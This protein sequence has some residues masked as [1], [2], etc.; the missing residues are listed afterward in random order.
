[1]VEANSR[2]SGMQQDQPQFYASLASHL[3]ADEQNVIQGAFQ[4]AEANAT[5]MALAY[6]QQEADQQVA[7]AATAALNGGAN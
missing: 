1:M 2:D 6:A 4:Q 3:S 7:Q 5:A